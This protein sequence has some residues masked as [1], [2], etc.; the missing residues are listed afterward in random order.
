[1]RFPAGNEY[2]YT[3][4]F[5]EIVPPRRLV[6]RDAPDGSRFGDPLPPATFVTSLDLAEA[7]GQ[8]TLTVHVTFPTPVARDA[9]VA[10]GDLDFA[11]DPFSVT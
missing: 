5:L 4:I 6:W 3:S 10:R 8:T 1:M 9:A 7:D 2:G 11:A